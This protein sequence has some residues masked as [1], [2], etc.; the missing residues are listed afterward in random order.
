MKFSVL[1]PTCLATALALLTAC[2]GGDEIDG[3]QW[4]S[5]GTIVDESGAGIGGVTVA[6]TLD[7]TYSTTT[8][9]SGNYTLDL[10]KSYNFP[11]YFSG[12]ATKQGILPKPVLFTYKNERLSFTNRV[13][14]RALL[15]SDVLFPASLNVVHLG[16]SNYAGTSNSQFQFPSASG[17]VWLDKATLDAE[18]KSKYS[19]L[20]IHFYAKGIERGEGDSGQSLISLSKNGQPGTYIVEGLPVTSS[21][22]SYSQISRCF[23][24]SSFQAADIVQVQ[25][26]SQANSGGDYDDFELIAVTGLLK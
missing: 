14:S 17:T 6:V 7:R 24:L 15:D 25:I 5:K 13:T 8:D 9:A 2:G 26:N 16:D 11:T 23:S 4:V 3:A 12:I 19:Q 18:Q 10:P 21:D 22:G 1:V 20:C